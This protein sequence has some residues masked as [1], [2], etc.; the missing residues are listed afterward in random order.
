MNRSTRGENSF[1]LLTDELA[2]ALRNYCSAFTELSDELACGRSVSPRQME[3]AVEAKLRLE[4]ARTLFALRA[5][6]SQG[7]H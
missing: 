6:P 4:N 1:N 5:S 7:A 2:A 3:R